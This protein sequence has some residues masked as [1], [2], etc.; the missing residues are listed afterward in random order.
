VHAPLPR[1]VP[2]P[3]P[4]AQS[5]TW[6]HA[7][8][9]LAGALRFGVNPSLGPVEAIC[10]R[11]GRPQ[12]WFAVVQVTGTNGKSSVARMAATL[13]AA[14]GRRVGLY[15]SPHLL[16]YCER[17]A[18]V[19]TD[20]SR[21]VPPAIGMAAEAARGAGVTPTEF[22][23]LTAAAL[24]LFARQDVEYAVLE[25]G[26]GG[27]WDATSVTTPAVAVITGVGL[28]HTD[29]LGGT[30][31]EIAADKAHIIKAGSV[32]L[33]GPGVGP[34]ARDVIRARADR[35]GAPTVA[36]VQAG[37]P[38]SSVS[39]ESTITFEVTGSPGGPGGVTRL[40]VS[41]LH[42]EYSGLSLPGPSFQA[43]NVATAIGAAES[44]LGGALGPDATRE[45]L[46]ALVVPGRFQLV[47]S[48][49]PTVVDGAHNPQA[50]E[51]LAGAV[52][53][54]WPSPAHRPV[55]VLGML[56]DK[57][58]A[59]LIAA[60]APVAAGFVVTEPAVARALGAS[61]LAAAVQ[62]ATV[63][64]PAVASSVAEA[65]ALARERAADGVLVTGSLYTVGEALR[66]LGVSCVTAGP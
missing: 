15:T 45:A 64:R 9:A 39:D 48:D 29:R 20:V 30:L 18:V 40:N 38:H 52:R 65:V 24:Y 49:P 3:S 43:P 6:A 51:M 21:D 22:E 12:D 56:A 26:L 33:L 27:R 42:T 8:A 44:A 19:G 34:Q 31:A 28:D 13:I 41:G 57:D 59:G 7:E 2:V 35:V 4:S 17:F 23:L 5:W 14:Q 32:A 37:S 54:A 16:S 47:A 66:A 58:A 63:T 53:E 50:A 10:E 25:V 60:L 62:E 46:A 36:V 55:V 11:L 61:A 1:S